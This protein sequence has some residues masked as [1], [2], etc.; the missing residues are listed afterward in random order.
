V[1]GRQ[2]DLWTGE[3]SEDQVA[4]D[5]GKLS[6]WGDRQRAIA[7]EMYLTKARVPPE[8]HLH[9]MLLLWPTWLEKADRFQDFAEYLGPLRWHMN[10][11]LRP[12][13]WY[14]VDSKASA[15]SYS[16]E[17]LEEAGGA[18]YQI[19]AFPALEGIKQAT[20]ALKRQQYGE[21]LGYAINA[22]GAC[23]ESQAARRIIGACVFR[24]GQKADAD[25]VVSTADYLTQHERN[26]LHSIDV[27]PKLL[28]Q[29]RRG[30]GRWRDVVQAFVKRYTSIMT[31]YRDIFEAARNYLQRGMFQ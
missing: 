27:L 25:W 24:Y 19:T 16:I 17:Q 8:L 29:T 13:G 1:S 26:L 30:H 22:L 9:E 6:P 4:G 11:A 10:N 2:L 5:P 14:I 21:A 23:H 31:E 28:R 7:T 3:V 20:D 15:L 18:P 12:Y